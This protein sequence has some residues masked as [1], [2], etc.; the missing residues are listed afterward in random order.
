[1]HDR[2]F[3]K[4]DYPFPK[5]IKLNPALSPFVV[6]AKS[7]KQSIDFSNPQGVYELNKALLLLRSNWT[8]W[9]MPQ[10]HLIPPIPGRED[11]IHHVADLLSES[12]NKRIPSGAEVRILDVGTGAGLVYPILANSIYKWSALASETSLDALTNAK[13]ILKNQG[14]EAME[15]ITLIHQ[16]K[17]HC[18]L[19]N[20]IRADEKLDLTICNPP[21]FRSKQAAEQANQTRRNK[22]GLNNEQSNFRGTDSELWTPGGEV[23]FIKK[24]IQESVDFKHQVMWFTSLVSRKEHLL[25]LSNYLKSLENVQARVIEMKHGQKKSRLLCWSFLTNEQHKLWAQFR[26]KKK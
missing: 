26:W 9:S 20:V 5:L 19:T 24:Y 14:A 18:I 3:F 23:I 12:N 1:M 4:K 13:I 10:K 6:K 21:F 11:Y 8:D 17:S 2:N 15:S 16:K 25:E 7:Q 22:M